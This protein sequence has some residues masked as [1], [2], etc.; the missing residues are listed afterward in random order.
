MACSRFSAI[1]CRAR[2]TL[3]VRSSA[4]IGLAWSFMDF[5][6]AIEGGSL[7]LHS[8]AEA[9]GTTAAAAVAVLTCRKRRRENCIMA[10]ECTA[11]GV[12]RKG[13]RVLGLGFQV[14]IG[15]IPPSPRPSCF[16]ALVRGFRCSFWQT[17][18]LGVRN[19]KHWGY[20]CSADGWSARRGGRRR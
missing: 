2:S 11:R 16:Q 9:A 8:A 20:G 4:L 19:R 12:G 6:L 18:A 15:V 3:A 17:Q 10:V 7:A 13:L 1:N 5:R 14:E